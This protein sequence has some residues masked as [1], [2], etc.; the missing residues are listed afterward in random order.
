MAIVICVAAMLAVGT[1]DSKENGPRVRLWYLIPLVLWVGFGWFHCIEFG[2]STAS[3]LSPGTADAYS[4]W[5]AGLS[6]S[7][8]GRNVFPLSVSPDQTR[9]S[10]ALFTLVLPL[11]WAASY[12]FADPTRLV[13][14]MAVTAVG[15][16]IHAAS[17]MLGVVVPEWAVLPLG[18]EAKVLGFGAFINRNNMSLHLNFGLAAALGLLAW[19]FAAKHGIRNRIST[20]DWVALF[21]DPVC[22]VASVTAVVCIAGLMVCGSRG[23]AVALLAGFVVLLVSRRGTRKYLIPAIAILFGIVILVSVPFGSD[24]KSIERIGEIN[25]KMGEGI[26]DDVRW[27]HWNDAFHTGVAYFPAGSG[28]GSY[29]YAY[30]PYQRSSIGAWF[31]HADNLW[32]ELFVVHGVLGI[33]FA[34]FFVALIAQSLQRLSRSEH[35]V[36]CGLCV[37]GAFGFGV[38]I[39][40]QIFDFG[41][42]IPANLTIFIILFAAVVVRSRIAG[43]IGGKGFPNS[44]AFAFRNTTPGTRAARLLDCSAAMVFVA[45]G[46]STLPTLRADAAD[47]F[48]VWTAAE[49]LS[50]SPLDLDA[51]GDRLNALEQRIE[52]RPTADLYC[53]ASKLQHQV[54]RLVETDVDPKSDPVRFAENYL[55]TK[56]SVH[57]E[58]WRNGNLD[59]R[60]EGDALERYQSSHRLNVDCLQRQPLSIEA[61]A[62]LIYLDFIHRDQQISR[63]A[64]TQLSQLQNRSVAQLIQLAFWAA[65][66]DDNDL[67]EQLWKSVTDLNPSQARF[68]IQF[69]RE[70]PR[71]RIEKCIADRPLGL[72]VACKQILADAADQ[73]DL[74]DNSKA[75]LRTAV[76]RF[77]CQACQSHD[78]TSRCHELAGNVYTFLGDHVQA[79]EQ[80]RSAIHFRPSDLSLRSN[81]ITRL[82]TAGLLDPAIDEAVN[83]SELFPDHKGFQ[84]MVRDL[85]RERSQIG[86]APDK[87][88]Q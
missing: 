62:G 63:R 9:H 16:S 86:P 3:W 42:I 43:P 45:A 77:E 29:A 70:N 59:I 30:L 69:A 32:L 38:V 68:A 84:A 36:D 54:A 28:F 46:L 83:A 24:A 76:N 71:V 57:R 8:F 13:M 82:R 85:L 1:L 75:F 80:Y 15:V 74:P 55:Q 25:L 11:A 14:L 20:I 21:R 2:A 17:A 61:R 60:S 66:G 58:A 34:M 18:S 51:L 73:Q 53:T 23:G 27:S 67:A 19:R 79:L 37:S 72:Q 48:V 87:S 40:S 10:A 78:E 41:L 7:E 35:S 22:L 6:Q 33:A 47:D 81:V 52:I 44:L 50:R 4:T 5:L 56:R 39:F 65:N 49:T 64:I 31:H 26:Q 88:S 12:V